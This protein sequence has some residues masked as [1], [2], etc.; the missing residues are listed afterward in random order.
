MRDL[1]QLNQ[2]LRFRMFQSTVL[3][4]SFHHLHL[5][6][7]HRSCTVGSRRLLKT[8]RRC[9]FVCDG[10]FEWKKVDPS[11]PK[12]GKQA[13]FISMGNDSDKVIVTT[14]TPQYSNAD[15]SI[16]ISIAIAITIFTIAVTIA[17]STSETFNVHGSTL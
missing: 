17:I 5:H 1:R 16:S 4:E 11:S 6:H 8:G 9:V 13:Y 10:F 15:L 12:L 2:S 3:N 7:H 14:N